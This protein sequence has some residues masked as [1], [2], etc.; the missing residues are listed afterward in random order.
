MQEAHAYCTAFD[1]AALTQLACALV[2]NAKGVEILESRWVC[3]TD[4]ASLGQTSFGCINPGTLFGWH[5]FPK[6][7]SVAYGSG[8]RAMYP[9]DRNAERGALQWHA[10]V[11]VKLPRTRISYVMDAL[12]A[13][14]EPLHLL[15]GGGHQGA[16]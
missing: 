13:F 3:S 5:Q 6:C 15:P 1:L 4:N 2:Q 8:G 12:Q 9:E 10:W 11:E 16:V 14:G 7:N